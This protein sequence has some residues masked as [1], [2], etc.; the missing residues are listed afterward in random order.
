MRLGLIG[1]NFLTS[2]HLYWSNLFT[3]DIGNKKIGKLVMGLILDVIY[4][5]N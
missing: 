3:R 2:C 4:R 5:E 1:F